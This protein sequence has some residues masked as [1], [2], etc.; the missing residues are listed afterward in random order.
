MASDLPEKAR[1]L[2]AHLNPFMEEH[3][4]WWLWGR[5]PSASLAQKRTL[6]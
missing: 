5:N 3:V 6:Q 4:V 2:A 1:A